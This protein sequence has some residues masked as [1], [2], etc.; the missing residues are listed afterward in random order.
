M[1]QT[2]QSPVLMA[3]DASIDG[4]TMRRT[5]NRTA[6]ITALL[7]MIREGDLHPGAAEIAERAGVSHR[8]IFRYF[9]DLDDLARTT[10]HQAFRDAAPLSTIPDPGVGSLADR[11]SRLVDSRLALLAYVD[12]PMQ[13]ARIRSYS[14]PSIDEEIAVIAEQ[15]RVQISEHFAA[16][17]AEQSL[18]ERE[19]IV[20]AVL[21]L[22][23]YDAY[24]IHTRLLASSTE[25]IRAAWVTALTALLS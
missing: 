14:I 9:D 25:R 21:V 19:F 11:V 5:R 22:T 17:L 13:L 20:D 6:V 12:G 7:D 1:T 18:P 8:S 24:T 10:I 3:T 23:S 16:E 4:R 15:F 2:P